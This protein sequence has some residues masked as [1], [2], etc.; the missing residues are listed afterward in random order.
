MSDSNPLESVL[1]L[2]KSDRTKQRCLNAAVGIL[3]SSGFSH[4]KYESIAQ[5]AGVTR[6]LVKKYF[7]DKNRLIMEAA[8]SVRKGY[9]EQIIAEMKERYGQPTEQLKIYIQKNLSLPRENRAATG[10]W[11]CS[12]HLAHLDRDSRAN[13]TSMTRMGLRADPGAAGCLPF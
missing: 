11:I 2:S 10:I 12:L 4:L 9:Q 13:N 1:K 5:E 8:A 6:P 3:S 7:P